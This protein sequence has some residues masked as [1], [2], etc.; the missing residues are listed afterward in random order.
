MNRYGEGPR[1]KPTTVIPNMNLAVT[2]DGLPLH[3]TD[4]S[5]ISQPSLETLLPAVDS[6]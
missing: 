3:R 6:N 4:R 2:P 1:G 5:V